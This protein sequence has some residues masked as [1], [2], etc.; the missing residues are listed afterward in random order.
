MNGLRGNCYIFKSIIWTSQNC[1][2]KSGR[3][4]QVIYWNVSWISGTG[5]TWSLLSDGPTSPSAIEP[6]SPADGA[7][8][9]DGPMSPGSKSFGTN[10]EGENMQEIGLQNPARPTEHYNA[11]HTTPGLQNYGPHYSSHKPYLQTI[12]G[13]IIFF[14]FWNGHCRVQSSG[15]FSSNFTQTKKAAM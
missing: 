13:K 7:S 11:I 3:S 4:K 15:F 12:F 6:S 10:L 9:D 1:A 2:Y 14:F 5:S 8:S